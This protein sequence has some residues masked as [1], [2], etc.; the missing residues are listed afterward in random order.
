MMNPVCI[1]SEPVEQAKFLFENLVLQ[2]IATE[3]ARNIL[4]FKYVSPVWGQ[5][6]GWY[7]WPKSRPGVYFL[8]L[9]S[10]SCQGNRLKSHYQ[11]CYYPHPEEN[12]FENYSLDE[13]IARLSDLFSSIKPDGEYRC[14]CCDEPAANDYADLPN[15]AGIPMPEIREQLNSWLFCIGD[16]NFNWDVDVEKLESCTVEAP[17]C[18]LTWAY[19]D[20]FATNKEGLEF[21]LLKKYEPDRKIP[22]WDICHEFTVNLLKD[23][24]IIGIGSTLSNDSYDDTA[25]IYRKHTYSLFYTLD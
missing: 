18:S 11:L 4:H 1:G 16:M 25:G 9:E 13:Q 22:S 14:E 8:R 5:K 19:M 3:D 10:S 6:P 21:S 17:D 15:G 12:V 24:S 7:F 23:L 20:V 2:L